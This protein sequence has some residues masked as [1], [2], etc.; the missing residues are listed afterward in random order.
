MEENINLK[1]SILTDIADNC[2]VLSIN[3]LNKIQIVLSTLHTVSN[4]MNGYI[5]QIVPN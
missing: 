5:Q 3:Y 4:D 2:S 1:S